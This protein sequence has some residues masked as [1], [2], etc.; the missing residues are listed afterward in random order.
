MSQS[1]RSR[2]G[3]HARIAASP[4]PHPGAGVILML[5]DVINEFTFAEA[6]AVLRQ[7]IPMAAHI[8][9]LKAAAQRASVPTIYVNDNFGNWK[10][11]F[12]RLVARAVRPRGRGRAVTRLLRPEPR[13]YFVLKPRHSGFFST[14]LTPLLEH[15]QAH[16]LILTGLLADV[17]VLFTAQ[18]AYM[19]GYR[20][21]VPGDCIAA[22]SARDRARSLAHM[23]RALDADTRPS[24]RIDV[25]RLAG[26]GEAEFRGP[27]AD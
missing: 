7:A 5:I 22:R 18:D 16:T 17:C 25:A 12:R 23:R 4:A 20:L 19:R 10:S 21:I 27:D 14:P 2:R 3:S 11:D 8:R 6:R 1:D 9:R 15:L 13:D 26:L 24:T